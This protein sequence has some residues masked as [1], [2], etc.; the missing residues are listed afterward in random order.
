[1]NDVHNIPLKRFKR[2]NPFVRK[3]SHY[4]V[5]ERYMEFDSQRPQQLSGLDRSFEMLSNI[6]KLAGEYTRSNNILSTMTDL[7][8]KVSN[9]ENQIAEIY[10]HNRLIPFNLI[11][12][13]SGYICRRCNKI[14]FIPIENIDYDKTAQARHYC[15]EDKVKTIKSVS[16]RPSDVFELYNSVAKI[17]LNNL[18]N[19]MPGQKYVT[20]EDRSASFNQL[21]TVL[22]PKIVKLLLGFP[23][24]NYYYKVNGRLPDWI[25]RALQNIGIKTSIEDS[26]TTDFL[27]R[28]TSTYAVFEIPSDQGLRRILMKITN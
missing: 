17:M 4:P 23:Y 24:R 12:G 8:T 2:Q 10:S 16:I 6:T 18:N 20:A 9:Y 28:V 3:R 19:I 27:R 11:Q 21:E 7:R 5:Y 13:L 25:N 1:M 26:E 15:D 14:S 22:D